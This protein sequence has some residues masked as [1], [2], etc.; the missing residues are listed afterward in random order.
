MTCVVCKVR[1][2]APCVLCCL[3]CAVRSDDGG[4][5]AC[6]AP[7]RAEVKDNGPGSTCPAPPHASPEGAAKGAAHPTRD[8][9]GVGQGRR[10]RVGSPF[11]RGP[12]A[13]F[14]PRRRLVAVLT[15]P[16]PGPPAQWL[17]VV[18][19]AV[20]PFVASV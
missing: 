6:G 13:P 3:G 17:L 11:R 16:L 2:C 14:E 9:R 15:S 19:V 18:M 7:P 5:S 1:L 20:V 4:A 10:S 12:R 8:P